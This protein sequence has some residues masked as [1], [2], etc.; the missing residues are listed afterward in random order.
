M[1]LLILV[2]TA[3]W[4]IFIIGLVIFIHEFGHFIS[5]K[6]AGVKVEEFAFGFGKKV[7]GKRIGETLYK[8]NLLPVGGYVRLL[9]QEEESK[10]PNSFSTK[11]LKVKMLVI[12][13]GVVM[14]FFLAVV[15]F[16]IVLSVRNYEIFIPR[17]SEYHF[18]GAAVSIHNKPIVANIINE[19]PA[20]EVDFPVDVVI[21]SVNGKDIE[22]VTDLTDYLTEHKGEEITIK[23]LS[24]Y[25]EWEDITVIPNDTNQEGV[26]LGVEF[27]DSIASFYKLD[28]G[29]T[30]VFS[31]F[32][33]TINFSG[34]TIDIF[35]DLVAI[36]VEEKSVKP[37]SE[38]VSG[39]VGVANRVFDLVKIGDI[40]EILNLIAGINLSLAIINLLPIPGLDGGYLLFMLIEKIRG[41]KIAEKYQEWAI[42]IGFIFLAFLGI[43]ITIKD[44]VQ[45]DI[46]GRLFNRISSLF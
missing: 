39:V 36:S 23:V 44:I 12:I 25:G 41:R 13:A 2:K 22:E 7:Y 8:I 4:F 42:K 30:K 40:I 9:G 46:I 43:L 31:G 21:W 33:H 34:Y 32:L 18:K 37:V 29:R 15:T 11:S 14:N 27:Y 35:K 6:L 20:E 16:Y 38:G 10:K 1:I 28:Y 26:L 45:F 3:I 24:F 19:T 17:I 5:A